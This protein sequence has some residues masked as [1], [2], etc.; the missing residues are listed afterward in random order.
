MDVIIIVAVVVAVAAAVAVAGGAAAVAVAVV[1]FI[2]VVEGK[3]GEEILRSFVPSFVWRNI[4]IGNFFKFSP[5]M[6]IVLKDI[7]EEVYLSFDLFLC[8][9]ESINATHF[10][11]ESG[12]VNCWM[13]TRVRFDDDVGVGR[14][15]V[16]LGDQ[17]SI[18]LTVCQ[19][20]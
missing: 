3:D 2:V 5:V 1:E 12:D 14:F 16:D 19:Y 13:V 6:P 17:L 7:K 20:I 18:F 9:A 10:T 8:R 15:A 11:F 4:G